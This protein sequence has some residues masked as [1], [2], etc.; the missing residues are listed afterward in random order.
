VPLR[1]ELCVHEPESFIE[2]DG[3]ERQVL[4]GVLGLTSP[5]GRSKFMCES[6]LADVA[7]SDASWS[8]TALRYF[9]PVGV[10]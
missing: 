6:I 1:E 4:P 10:E 8:I 5:Y 7:R 3:T 9:N 2:S